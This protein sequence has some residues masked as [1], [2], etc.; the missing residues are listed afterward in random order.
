M[1]QEILVARLDEARARTLALI[2]PL[3]DGDLARAVEEATHPIAWD[4]LHAANHEERWLS[5]LVRG[6]APLDPAL[7][8]ALDPD[9]V[10]RERRAGLAYPERGALLDYLARVRRATLETLD[11]LDATTPEPLLEG[12]LLVD[13]VVQHE[14][15]HQE[16]I[17]E[18][19]ARLEPGRYRPPARRSFDGAPRS[20]A[21]GTPALVPAGVFVLGARERSAR[22]DE[23]PDH[24]RNLPAFVLD[25][26]PASETDFLA[27]V[28]ERGYERS[29]LWTREGWSWRCATS[30]RAPLGW[31]HDGRRWLARSFDVTRPL[32]GERPV[33]SL[34]WFEADAY[35]RF[36]GK[37]LPSEAEWEKA[38]RWGDRERPWGDEPWS[39]ALANLD[40]LA[41]DTA[42]AGA[43]A[44]GRSVLGLEQL[45]GDVWEWTASDYAPYPRF[46]SFPERARGPARRGGGKVLR[47][48]SWATRPSVARPTLRR[49]ELPGRR[50]AFAGVR[51]ASS[52][53]R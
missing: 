45:L 48:G 51:C 14:E 27:F 12:G 34:S 26:R 19:A 4:L 52:G 53:A 42:P 49:R 43:V 7:E 22:D 10:P 25:P 44:L 40:Q 36:R 47:G 30:A 23:R 11:Q 1:R 50:H 16:S 46:E 33:A 17:L 5:R 28:E 6:G 13:L 31:V 39:P 37:R 32:D 8:R 29:E 21:R 38:A 15:R 2:E 3:A 20:R 35:A 24:E 9:R 41:F 18:T